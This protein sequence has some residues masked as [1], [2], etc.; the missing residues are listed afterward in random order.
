MYKIISFIANSIFIG[1][2]ILLT[3]S[4]GLLGYIFFGL[5]FYDYDVETR[6]EPAQIVSTRFKQGYTMPQLVSVGKTQI[7]QNI[8]IDDDWIANVKLETRN[9][10]VECRI[11]EQQFNTLKLGDLVEANTYIGNKCEN[12]VISK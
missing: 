2:F 1:Y 6:L 4:L 12:L 11:T 10:N 8:T 5:L 7:V 9:L 3:L